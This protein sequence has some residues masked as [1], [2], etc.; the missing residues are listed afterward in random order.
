[1]SPRWCCLAIALIA[2]AG[3]QTLPSVTGFP[4]KN[5]HIQALGGMSGLLNIGSL[6]SGGL[7]GLLAALGSVVQSVLNLV[8]AVLQ[9]LI[10]SLGIPGK[11]A[12]APNF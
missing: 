7:A 6:T 9:G 4:F 10:G 2:I 5:L 12:F 8:G 3:A 1:M 11:T